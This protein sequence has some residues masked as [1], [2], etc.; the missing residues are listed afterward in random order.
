[1]HHLGC[2]WKRILL[3]NLELGIMEE[4]L[5][6]G[7]RVNGPGMAAPCKEDPGERGR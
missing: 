6:C 4:S 7:L 5:H 2:C 1:M 3:N